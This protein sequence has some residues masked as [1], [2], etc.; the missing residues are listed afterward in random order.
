MPP[1]G[2][3]RGRGRDRLTALPAGRQNAPSAGRFGSRRAGIDPILW[4]R[5]AGSWPGYIF[6]G[7]PLRLRA[8]YFD[9]GHGARAHAP[10][11]YYL[12]ESRNPKLAGYDDAIRGSVDYLYL[13]A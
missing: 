5:S 8:G 6:T 10:D 4:P 13:L 1:S 7:K 3:R 2:R 12:L 11:E 9:L